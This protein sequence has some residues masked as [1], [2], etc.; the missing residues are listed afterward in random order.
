M[1]IQRRPLRYLLIFA[2][3]LTLNSLAGAQS[4]ERPDTS[5]TQ[6]RIEGWIQHRNGRVGGARVRLLRMPEMRP[7][8]ETFSRPEGQFVF[9]QVTEGDY[10]IETFETESF[11]ATITNVSV[12]PP[13]GRPTAIPVFVELSLKPPPNTTPP[14]VVMADVDLDVPKAALKHFRAGMK[15]LEKSDSDRALIELREAIRIHPK[16]YAARLELGRELRLQK[17][18]QEAVKILQPLGQIAPRRVEAHIEYG[19]ALLSLGHREAA[20]DE[21]RIAVQLQESNWAAHLYLGW[22]LLESDGEKAEPHL[23][24]AIE[25]DE[26][27]AARAHLALARLADAKGERQLALD[28]LDAYLAL[29]PNAHDAEATRKLAE[30]LRGHD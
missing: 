21:L 27:K 20:T 18:F 3:I 2:F 26:H 10:A 22:S 13:R 17:L 8:T 12:R 9:T 28:H 25:I 15:A 11:E 23:K 5:N 1:T 7:I 16:Y 19:I 29:A 30:R 4:V 6:H 14:G 24:R